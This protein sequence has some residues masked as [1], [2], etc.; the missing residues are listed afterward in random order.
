M[1]YH[2]QSAI[3]R[4]FNDTISVQKSA[5]FMWGGE[6]VLVVAGGAWLQAIAPTTA[7]ALE[8]VVR[9][10]LGGLI[11]LVTAF[12]I[13][14]AYNIISTPYKQRNEVLTEFITLKQKYEEL[15]HNIGEQKQSGFQFEFNDGSIATKDGRILLG[16]TFY[17]AV[18]VIVDKL[19]LE[20]NGKQF[21]PI[22]WAP[23][24]LRYIHTENYIFDMLKIEAV[25]SS[26]SPNAKFVA[27]V[28]NVRHESDL[29]NIHR[30]L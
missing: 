22:D 28:E 7:S 17:S 20:T 19:E 16:V 13:V 12:L 25:V 8:I 14:L 5:R 3:R 23:F 4:A 18:D 11:G 10:V 29:F 24:K 6:G 9:S 30:L 2:Q 26:E 15:K 1:E 21:Q 27:F